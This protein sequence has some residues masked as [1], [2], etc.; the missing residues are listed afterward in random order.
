MF[1]SERGTWIDRD[2]DIHTDNQTDIGIDRWMG[3]RTDVQE[4]PRDKWIDVRIDG[5][6][7]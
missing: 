6:T 4:G 2:A 5:Q 3:E 1:I 7:A